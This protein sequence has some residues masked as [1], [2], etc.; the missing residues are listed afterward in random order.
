MPDTA[1]IRR[2]MVE[3][4]LRTN[5]VTDEA[6]LAAMEAVPRERFVP[7][8]LAGV[9]YIDDDLPLGGGRYLLEPML[10]AWLLQAAAIRPADLV[11]DVGCATGYSTAVIARLAATV[12]ALESDPALARA[13]GENLAGL[14][15]D[16][17]VVVAG[18]LRAGYPAHAPYDVIVVE[19]AVPEIPAALCQQLAE[20]GRLAAVLA[21]PG[22]QGRVVLAIKVGGIVSHRDISD[23]ATPALPGFELEPGF[24]F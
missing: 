6:V 16:N 24:R 19:G 15:V 20:G 11:L 12:L 18:A 22:Q 10:F 5:R 23:A 4:Q 7:P 17:A 1:A 3:S 14:E 8:A 13:A 21:P 2:T 9:A